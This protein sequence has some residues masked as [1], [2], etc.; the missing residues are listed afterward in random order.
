MQ[1]IWNYS[2]VSTGKAVKRSKFQVVIAFQVFIYYQQSTCKCSIIV[3][4]IT[5]HRLKQ[6]V[7]FWGVYCWT[8]EEVVLL[9]YYQRYFIYTRNVAP[10][11]CLFNCHCLIGFYVAPTLLRSYGCFSQQYPVEED[12]RFS[13]VQC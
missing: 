5:V 3:D 6:R 4:F 9:F 1:G 13:T 12:I 8:T 2:P 7:S 11:L 10:L